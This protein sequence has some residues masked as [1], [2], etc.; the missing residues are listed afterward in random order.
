MREGVI[1]SQLTVEDTSKFKGLHKSFKIMQ[2]PIM[3]SL[4]LNH[5][6]WSLPKE[7]YMHASRTNK[8]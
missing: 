2:N 3:S 4:N 7:V 8:G 5:F 6:K 1:E